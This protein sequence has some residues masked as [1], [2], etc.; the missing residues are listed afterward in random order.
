VIFEGFNIIINEQDE[1]MKLEIN[2]KKIKIKNF[3]IENILETPNEN[4]TIS[5]KTRNRDLKPYDVQV[6]LESPEEE[7]GYLLSLEEKRIQ[8][9]YDKK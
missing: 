1:E 2:K 4:I 7:N 6:W 9:E 5:M 8:I 3:E